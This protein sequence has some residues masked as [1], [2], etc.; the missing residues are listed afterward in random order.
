MAT[1]SFS[2]P[3]TAL[4]TCLLWLLPSPID[5]ER[6][7]ALCVAGLAAY[8]TTEWNNRFTLLRIR[9]RLMSCTL[10][11]LLTASGFLHER[12]EFLLPG[13]C[14]LLAFCTLFASYQQQHTEAFVFHA[15]L[16]TGIGSLF[17]PPMLLLAA[18]HSVSMLIQLRVL[19]WRTL[20][21]G[22]LGLL[23]PYCFAAAWLMWHGGLVA[24]MQGFADAFDF[25]TPDYSTLSLGE[26]L[27]FIYVTF[28]VIGGM[29]HFMRT[30]FNDKIRTRMF[31]YTLMVHSG[32][33]LTAN[34]LLPRDFFHIFPLFLVTSA[35][36]VAHH[37][38]LSRGRWMNFWFILVLL[39]GFGLYLFNL[40]ALW[41]S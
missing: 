16:F 14:L 24:A 13:L 9:S 10:L 25:R 31:F 35:P 11:F 22:L 36:L 18:A 34:V 37:F 12:P 29:I 28:L 15:F 40:I 27:T 2:L 5:G 32:V 8:I 4:L 33:L 23:L 41:K 19:T 39:L 1:G 17:Y 21:A 26:I 6:L 7:A 3:V 20:A 38:A 30:S